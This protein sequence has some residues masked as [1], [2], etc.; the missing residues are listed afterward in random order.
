MTVPRNNSNLLQLSFGVSELADIQRLFDFRELEE[1]PVP[2]DTILICKLDFLLL[3][4]AVRW[5]AGLSFVLFRMLAG[6]FDARKEGFPILQDA[7][8]HPL[9]ALCRQRPVIR[10]L[11][12]FE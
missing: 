7:L 1:L 5:N 12:D 6:V 9:A 8:H 2:D 3:G 10:L 4:A 11:H